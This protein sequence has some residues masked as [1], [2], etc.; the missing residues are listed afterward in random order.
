MLHEL[1]THINDYEVLEDG[2]QYF[3]KSAITYARDD[4]KYKL[5]R[6]HKIF[7]EGKSIDRYVQLFQG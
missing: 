3:I 4:F 2:Y 7:I 1:L 6:A 5:Y